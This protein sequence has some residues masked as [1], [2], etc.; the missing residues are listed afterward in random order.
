MYWQGNVHGAGAE[1]GRSDC[2]SPRSQA[3]KSGSVRVPE[4]FK[5]T[6]F[7]SAIVQL[8]L[9]ALSTLDSFCYILVPVREQGLVLSSGAVCWKGDPNH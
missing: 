8:L 2:V 4:I 1:L 9:T 5:G 6:W 7:S 3:S